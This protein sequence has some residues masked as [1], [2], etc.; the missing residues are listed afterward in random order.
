VRGDKRAGGSG[1]RPGGFANVGA[2][3]GGKEPCGP[4]HGDADGKETVEVWECH[5]DCPVR[6]LDDQ[7][8]VTQ[9][10]AMKR[11]VGGYSS[12]GITGFIR[13]EGG[14]HNQHGDK[15][16]ASRFF[17]QCD[18]DVEPSCANCA[19][20]EADGTCDPPLTKQQ[21]EGMFKKV[22]DMDPC[23]YH[24]QNT[25]RFFYCA[26]VN[27][28]ERTDNG[29][30]VNKHPT[31]KPLALMEYLCKLVRTPTGGII[32]D[33]FA[34][35][36]TTGLAARSVGCDFVLIEKELNSARVAQNRV[37]VPLVRFC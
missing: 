10:G 29:R 18:P 32:L 17:Q 20:R 22:K 37:Q 2:E 30:V 13:G 23:P 7:S 15:G 12:D 9:S 28:K 33:P 25:T 1:K 14:P 16:G 36:G 4:C 35:S 19:W 5:P 26:K 27:K 11:K 8:G 21:S 31:V 6:L 24:S 34:G 3:K